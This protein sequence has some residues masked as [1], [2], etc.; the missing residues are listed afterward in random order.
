[1]MKSFFFAL[2]LT[3]TIIALFVDESS[4]LFRECSVACDKKGVKCVRDCQRCVK[5]ACKSACGDNLSEPKC[6]ECF[7]KQHNCSPK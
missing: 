1:M 6:V 5:S 4:A 2:L 3:I 7:D